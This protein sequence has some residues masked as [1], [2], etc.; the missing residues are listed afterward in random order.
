MNRCPNTAQPRRAKKKNRTF[1]AKIVGNSKNFTNFA[2]ANKPNAQVAELVDAHVSGA[3]AARREGS[4]P[5]L[6][7][8][9][10]PSSLAI[11]LLGFLFCFKKTPAYEHNATFSCPTAIAHHRVLSIFVIACDGHRSKVTHGIKKRRNSSPYLLKSMRLRGGHL[12][13]GIG[14]LYNQNCDFETPNA[15]PQNESLIFI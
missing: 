11:K 2:L 13:F 15:K 8:N 12:L 5:F 6:G 1:W 7:T 3:C 14:L 10:R 9:S 4:S